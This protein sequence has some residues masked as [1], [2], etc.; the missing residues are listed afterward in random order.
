MATRRRRASERIRA[1]GGQLDASELAAGDPSPDA[2]WE[3]IFERAMLA[4]LLDVVRREFS[5]ETY[6][7]F[8]LLTLEGLPGRQAAAITGRAA[9]PCT[10]P[11][12]GC[13]SGFAN[14]DRRT[15]RTASLP[16]A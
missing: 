3:A 9:M 1:E 11:G 15:G 5:P 2:D 14:W 16:S 8:E 6:Q 10:L 7:A 13:S 12:G 4:A